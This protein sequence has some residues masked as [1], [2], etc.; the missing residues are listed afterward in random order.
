MF[1]R[2]SMLAVAGAA[3]VAALAVSA[4]AQPDLP[5]PGV[6]EPGVAGPQGLSQTCGFNSGPR[7]G[8]VIDYPGS[9]PVPLG[10]HCADMQGS[11]GQAVAQAPRIPEQNNGR[12]YSYRG[13]YRS[14]GA[15]IARDQSGNVSA[16]FSL[17]CRLNSGRR[18]GSTVDF[19]NTL[20]AQP[21]AIGAPCA[22]DSGWGVAVA[23]GM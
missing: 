2:F 11:S 5:Q 9:A 16:G 15:P 6:A 20:G 3:S 8:Q 12:Y 19:S 18:A 14:P 1:N 22:D 10:S 21:V 4:Q 13:F 17:T 23:S 7:A